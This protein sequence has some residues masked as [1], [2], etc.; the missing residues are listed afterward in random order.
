[1]PSLGTTQEELKAATQPGG[2]YY[3]IRVQV[4][5]GQLYIDPV[6]AA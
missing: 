3:I 4:F 2:K 5:A 1:M 6:A